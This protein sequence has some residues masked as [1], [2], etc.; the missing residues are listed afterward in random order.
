MP[1]GRWKVKV[2]YADQAAGVTSPDV[3]A[4]E[5]LAM[6]YAAGSDRQLDLQLVGCLDELAQDSRDRA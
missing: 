3:P 2:R 5:M 4:T 6:S 1:A